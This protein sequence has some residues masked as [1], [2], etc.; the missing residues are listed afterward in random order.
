[1]AQ[2]IRVAVIEDD[3]VL[4]DSLRQ[5]VSHPPDSE[6][7]G[8]WV[9]GSEALC[10]IKTVAPDVVLLDINLGTENGIDCIPKL[11]EL[12]PKTQVMMLT[13]Y[14]DTENIFRALSAG[15]TGYLVKRTGAPRLLEAI[16]DLHA[17]QSPMSGHIARKLVESL[18]RGTQAPVSTSPL[19]RLTQREHEVLSCL[20]EGCLYKETGERLGM[21]IHTVRT[22]IRALYEK[23]QV[24]SRTEAVV[25][26]LNPR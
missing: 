12:C 16:A 9:S 19:A 3:P 17:G 11:K 13:V 18:G 25:K 7:V 23:L 14:E 2:P 22:H 4:R 26:F 15:A 6:S 1:M 10:H 8:G 20:A 5:L 21:S 24:R